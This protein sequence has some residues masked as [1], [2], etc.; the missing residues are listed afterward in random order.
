MTTRLAR[1]WREGS[2]Y[3]NSRWLEKL[4]WHAN[5]LT[6]LEAFNRTGRVLNITATSQRKHAPPVLLNYLTAPHVTIASAILAS[7]AVPLL[8]QPVVLQERMK[9]GTLRPFRGRTAQYRDGIIGQMLFG[10]S[11]RPN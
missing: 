9:D 4:R 3:S 5:D 7:S 2:L 10:F 8:V 6:F 1:F 11:S